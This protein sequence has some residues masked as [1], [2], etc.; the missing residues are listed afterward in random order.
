M[1][2]DCM[3][4]YAL[5][6]QYLKSKEEKDFELLEKEIRPIIEIEIKKQIREA[7]H[8]LEDFYQEIIFKIFQ[9]F[10]NVSF[11]LEDICS[12]FTLIKNKQKVLNKKINDCLNNFL[13][14]EYF[15]QEYKKYL[16]DEDSLFEFQFTM[17]LGSGRLKCYVR[18]VARER[19]STFMK[20]EYANLQVVSLN[21]INDYGTEYL[22]FIPA[23][24]SYVVLRERVES[25]SVEDQLFLQKFFAN[26]KILTQKEVAEKEQVSQ[27]YI[28]M[29]FNGIM[30]KVKR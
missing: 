26:G 5:Y 30:K 6:L 9:L 23:K 7:K 2:G 21:D 1:G 16:K 3:S 10:K 18:K 8:L 19:T 11:V 24:D 12:Y 15:F 28:S 27:Q 17:F 29:L 14:E 13:K 25:L 20:K 4:V 22:D